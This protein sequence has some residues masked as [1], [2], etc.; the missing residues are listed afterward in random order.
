MLSGY[1][2]T[3]SRW[4]PWLSS[5]NTR[6][7]LI[8]LVSLFSIDLTF[9]FIFAIGTK[10]LNFCKLTLRCSARNFLDGVVVP[11]NQFSGEF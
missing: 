11:Q 4:C 8:A 10:N 3:L 1:S 5:L 9:H 6:S 2:T 7:L